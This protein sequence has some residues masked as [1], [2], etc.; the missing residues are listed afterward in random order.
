VSTVINDN[1][2]RPCVSIAE[3]CKATFLLTMQSERG[4]L[5]CVWVTPGRHVS[6]SED[7]CRAAPCS[8]S[9]LSHFS[10]KL[11]VRHAPLA[12]APRM[13]AR[14]RLSLSNTQPT[15]GDM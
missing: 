10:A 15:L 1:G 12:L 5:P 2:A 6:W 13:I 3:I 14:Q 7:T 9:S 11:E 8:S 4:L